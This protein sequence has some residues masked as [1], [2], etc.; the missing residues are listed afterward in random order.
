MLVKYIKQSIS[1][2]KWLFKKKTQKKEYRQNKVFALINSY[3][4]QSPRCVFSTDTALKNPEKIT[5][6]IWNHFDTG[7]ALCGITGTIEWSGYIVDINYSFGDA[8]S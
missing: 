3:N 7:D 5:I 2:N 6:P 1:G 4:P 8:S